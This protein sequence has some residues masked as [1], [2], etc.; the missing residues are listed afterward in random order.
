MGY[1][2][3]NLIETTARQLA[4]VTFFH[5]EMQETL[6]QEAESVGAEVRPGVNV[7]NVQPG[8]NPSVLM[9]NNGRARIFARLMDLNEKD[10]PTQS[11][12]VIV[13]LLE[14]RSLGNY[15]PSSL[16]EFAEILS[17]RKDRDYSV[18]KPEF[19]SLGKSA[20]QQN[21]DVRFLRAVP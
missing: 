18:T 7:T 20:Y 19:R 12:R 5:L 8:A 14:A 13:P 9:A 6:L 17:E 10:R 2:P 4:G 15:L 16:S 11:F 1:G 3:L 21:C